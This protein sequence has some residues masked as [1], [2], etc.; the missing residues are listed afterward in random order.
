MPLIVIL[1]IIISSLL[2][3]G[4]FLIF[5]GIGQIKTNK[6]LWTIIEV[7]TAI[8]LPLFFLLTMD[9]GKV[10]DCCGDSA[11]FSPEHRYGIYILLLICIG[12]YA[13]SIFR[14]EIFAPI[15]ELLINLFFSIRV[16][17]EF[18]ALRTLRCN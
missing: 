11:I 3:F 7:W 9:F 2:V 1:L 15:A 5:A 8:I 16:G 13:I 17:A 12:A 14:R 18:I 4:N 10:N 6:K